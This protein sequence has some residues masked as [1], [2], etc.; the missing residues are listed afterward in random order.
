MS[1]SNWCIGHTNECRHTIRQLQMCTRCEYENINKYSDIILSWKNFSI[2]PEKVRESLGGG[3][4]P[5]EKDLKEEVD[6]KGFKTI[7]KVRYKS[8]HLKEKARFSFQ[9]KKL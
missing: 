2:F 1:K 7:E 6:K 4:P 8:S 9:K 5:H 3:T